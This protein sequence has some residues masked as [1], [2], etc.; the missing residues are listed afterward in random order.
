MR[1]T[2][3]T[4]RLNAQGSTAQ[5][6]NVDVATDPIPRSVDRASDL[7]K[8]SSLPRRQ[9]S[10]VAPRRTAFRSNADQPQM[11][12]RIVRQLLAVLAGDV[13]AY[14]RLIEL[15]DLG[16]VL[17]IWALRRTVVEPAAALYNAQIIRYAGDG[18]LI[19]FLESESAVECGIAIQHG[20]RLLETDV[21]EE[22]RI[23]LRMGISIDEVLVADGDFHGTGVNVAARLEALAGP[24]EIYLSETVFED[25]RSLFP[26]RFEAL[27]AQKLK[28]I[29]APVRVYR[30][31]GEELGAA[32]LPSSCSKQREFRPTQGNESA[33]SG[34]EL[35]L[36]SHEVSV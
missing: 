1:A 35:P 28:N 24:G 21:S 22:F 33:K 11:P 34:V 19:A 2:P 8:R 20:L 15:D 27:G 14:S 6:S 16:T 13:A 10:G 3:A 23:Q 29:T 12:R 30:I 7:G 18:F 9:P 32:A 4:G 17:R 36:A 26:I 5:S 25:V 31:P